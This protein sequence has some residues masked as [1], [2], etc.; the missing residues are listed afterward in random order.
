MDKYELLPEQLI[1]EGTITDDN[2]F[3]PDQLL[4]EEVL[5]THTVEYFDKLKE[6]RLTRKEA[7]RIGFPMTEA[8]VFR[9]LHI[10][11]G[12]YE[13]ALHAQKHGVAMNIAGGT[14]HAFPDHGEGFC[15]FNDIAIASNLLLKNEEAQRILIVDLDV[16]QGNGTAYIFADDPRVFTLSMHGGKNYPLRKE[17][18]DLDVPLADGTDG[19]TYLRQ[20][21]NHLPRVMTEFEPDMMFYLSGVDVL[22]TDKLGRL[23]LTKSECRTRDEYVLSVAK[24]NDVPVA[25]AMGGGY[26]E[27]IADIV[28]AHANTYRVA[29]E[30]F[31]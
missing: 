25:V 14:H 12:T 29:Q 9:G 7:R 18:S 30:I 2:F 6:Q 13:C 24:K 3:H 8:L 28:D 27:R 23:G 26:S 4:D 10:A 5:T 22:A 20:L 21:R 31:F 16:H 1:H 17:V 19:T 11:R 15:V